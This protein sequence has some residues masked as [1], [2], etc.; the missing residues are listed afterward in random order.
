M[1]KSLSKSQFSTEVPML[2]LHK[3][4]K[5]SFVH[6]EIPVFIVQSP[7]LD[8]EFPIFS[9]KMIS[10]LMVKIPVFD[11]EIMV[12]PGVPHSLP[13]RRQRGAQALQLCIPSRQ[14]GLGAAAGADASPWWGRA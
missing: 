9:G 8:G 10:F 5:N 6:G 4:K 11:G 13:Q 3:L 1:V 14:V 12:I 2:N 7:I